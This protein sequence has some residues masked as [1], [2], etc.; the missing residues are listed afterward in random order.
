VELVNM[1]HGWLLYD[2]VEVLRW[3]VGSGIAR[4]AELVGSGSRAAAGT[5]FAAIRQFGQAITRACKL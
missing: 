3:L 1:W 2:L 4:R 5:R